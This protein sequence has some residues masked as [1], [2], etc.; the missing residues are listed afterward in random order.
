MKHLLSPITVGPKQAKNRIMLC[1]MERNYGHRDGTASETT[2]AHYGS[3]AAGGVGWLDVEATFVDPAGRARSHQLGLHDDICVPG[4]TQLAAVAHRHGALIGVELVHG[5]RNTSTA[6]SGHQVVG[7]SAVPCM[8][9]GGDVPH[10]LTVDE[11]Q[12]IVGRYGAAARRARAA[13]F[14]AVELHSAHGYLP[15]AF[16][17]PRTN[18]RADEYGGSRERRMRFPL[19]AIDALRSEAG[20]DMI[21]G[22]RFSADELVP[23]G[24]VLEDAIEYAKAL[25]EHGV[26]YLSISVGVYES[27]GFI[28]A[29]MA[30]GQG[31]ILPLAAAIKA[32]VGI[33]VLC[34]GRFVDPAVA[35]EAIGAGQIDMVGMGR[36]LLTDPQL[37]NKVAAGRADDI[38]HCIGC[39]QGC[40]GRLENGQLDVTCLVN[41][42]VGREAAFELRPAAT[43]K[44]VAVVGGGPA[45]ME[46]ARVAAER[47][48]TVTLFERADH[49][50]GLAAA[51]ATTPDRGDWA[52][53][54]ADGS[55]RL[56]AGGVDVRLGADPTVDELTS[57]DAVVM[58][59]GAR[60]NARRIDGANGLI[61]DP[62]EI[63]S[64][65][66]E[67]RRAIVVKDPD[68]IALGVA[69]ALLARG[70]EVHLVGEEDAFVDPIGDPGALG[71]LRATGRLREHPA[72]QISRVDD[73][74]AILTQHGA[75][76]HL[77]E[78][79]I[80]APDAIVLCDDRRPRDDLAR[81]LRERA[82]D[83]EVVEIGDCDRPRSALEAIA[84]GAFAGR[85]L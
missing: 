43:P 4:F 62:L 14:D 71:R 24:F 83:H 16:V 61:A 7:P 85:S 30:I 58:A 33:P 10:E 55:R 6:T 75:V 19:E 65:S 2:L 72:R 38:V 45:G 18:L 50:G 81:K 59:T 29:P 80:P 76:A 66:A 21:V 5:G 69:G 60:F 51:A 23:G 70:A 84:A 73:G 56:A 35:D 3:I 12:A 13:G 68:H 28:V 53:L 26:D 8:E 57:A 32:E 20:D 36:A 48:H 52:R 27:A 42:S 31:W 22:C 11:I 17:S 44:H 74:D 37:P 67:V 79:V 82:P 9:A 25:E 1:P 54:V 34:S 78:E 63:M 41:P 46:A 49:L 15:F 64:D 40:T 47:G 39:N 77:Y